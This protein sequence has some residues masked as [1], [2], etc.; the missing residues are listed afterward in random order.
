MMSSLTLT[1]L[2]ADDN[3]TINVDDVDNADDVNNVN[4]TDI[5]NADDERRRRSSIEKEKK[6]RLDS[7]LDRV[8]RLVIR[9]FFASLEI[10]QA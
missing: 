2:L 4:D 3:N 9:C 6:S 10:N 8:E 7:S 1:L 5:D